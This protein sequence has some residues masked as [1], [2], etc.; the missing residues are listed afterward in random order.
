MVLLLEFQ[1]QV[2]SSPF[3]YRLLLP[4]CLHL[5]P[6]S[7]RL[8]V[9]HPTPPP[10]ILMTK[11]LHFLYNNDPASTFNNTIITSYLCFYLHK[12]TC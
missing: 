6:G 4:S 7:S 3:S 10:F 8:F 5:C 12:T 1:R 2:P 9:I 11:R